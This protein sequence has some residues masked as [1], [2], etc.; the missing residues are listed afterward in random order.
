MK[1]IESIPKRFTKGQLKLEKLLNTLGFQ[2][3]LEYEAG[4][5]FIDIYIPE[6]SLG[7]E[8]D[9]MGHFK[10]RDVKRDK[11]ILDNLGIKIIRIKERELNEKA[12]QDKINEVIEY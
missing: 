7:V 12:I 6:I 9:G 2:T 10:R 3:V 4:Q 11:E 1:Q 5:Y 8:F